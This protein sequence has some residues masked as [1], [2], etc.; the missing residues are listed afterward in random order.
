MRAKPEAGLVNQ[1]LSLLRANG[2]DAVAI[3]GLAAAIAG[4]EPAA[5][6]SREPATSGPQKT[7]ERAALA[8]GQLKCAEASKLAQ[9]AAQEQLSLAEASAGKAL[10]SRAFAIALLCADGAGKTGTAQA[11]ADRLRALAKDSPKG[12][13]AATW[14]RYPDVDVATNV[15]LSRTKISTTPA[16]ARV[17]I[18]LVPV[19]VAPLELSLPAG[20]HWVVVSAPG[21]ARVVRTL[22]IEERKDATLS[23]TVPAAELDPRK[24]IGPMAAVAPNKELDI[25]RVTLAMKKA[26]LA[27]LAV[28][29]DRPGRAGASIEIFVM[30]HADEPAK[31]L[32]RGPWGPAVRE[33][34][35]DVTHLPFLPTAPVSDGGSRP[36]IK[37]W[38]I[39]GAAIGAVVLGAGAIVLSE[40]ADD[41]QRIQVTW[42]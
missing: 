13:P 17:S 23:V 31:L 41:T 4:S 20:E 18:D 19:G 12:I 38:W 27:I 29:R 36:R 32:V 40:M 37:R 8:F 1:L 14:K 35:Y 3:S 28:V 33:A 15:F 34:V 30:T 25:T 21:R 11:F 42:P 39:W 9:A 5:S 6:A 16:G 2:T 7:L 10:L 22:V 26:S 24:S